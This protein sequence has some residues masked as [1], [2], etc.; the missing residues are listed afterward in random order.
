MAARTNW[1]RKY[2]LSLVFNQS[3][4]DISSLR[5]NSRKK[6]VTSKFIQGIMQ[7]K[8]H[9]SMY[10]SSQISELS[11][12]FEITITE[13]DS[14]QF[15]GDSKVLSDI[16]SSDEDSFSSVSDRSLKNI[17]VIF[18][19]RRYSI[20]NVHEPLRKESLLKSD[21]NIAKKNVRRGKS[22][23]ISRFGQTREY[24]SKNTTILARILLISYLVKARI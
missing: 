13:C 19:N 10:S 5:R 24:K 3:M 16:E 15:N 12:K 22:L 6:T 17:E 23:K 8:Q 2:L 21:L 18:D 11:N 7:H 20:Q 1:S 14:I 9:S 4:K